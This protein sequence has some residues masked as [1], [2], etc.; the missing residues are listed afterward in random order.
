MATITLPRPDVTT[1]QIAG[2]LRQGLG[3]RYH[4][5]IDSDKT[6]RLTVGRGSARVF[7]ARVTISRQGNQTALTVH[8]GGLTPPLQIVNRVWI[9][10]RVVSALR[11]APALR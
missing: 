9:V 10:T 3:P 7:R 1:D 4:V 6:D 5:G 8:S 2:A 11:N